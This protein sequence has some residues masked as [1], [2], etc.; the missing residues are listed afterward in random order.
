[1]T[2]AD[3]NEIPSSGASAVRSSLES[4]FAFLVSDFAAMTGTGFRTKH[5]QSVSIA[6][7][8]TPSI[9]GAL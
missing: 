2:D 8:L 4:A 6:F 5:S 7:D 1:M 9:G 3:S